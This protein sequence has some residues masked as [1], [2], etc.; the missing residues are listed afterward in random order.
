MQQIFKD[1]NTARKAGN[2]SVI[3]NYY[4]M[5]VIIVRTKSVFINKINHIQYNDEYVMLFIFLYT[6]CTIYIYI[7]M[8]YILNFIFILFYIIYVHIYI[9]M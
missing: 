2:T 4:K 5:T 8:M 3:E 9:M 6:K 7:L 1:L